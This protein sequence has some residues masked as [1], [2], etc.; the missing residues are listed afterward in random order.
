[1][2]P[3]LVS[4]A[5]FAMRRTMQAT[6]AMQKAAPGDVD[7]E[8]E[9]VQVEVALDE[10][11]P[12]IGLGGHGG[13]SDKQDDHGDV[14]GHMH[15]PGPRRSATFTC[16]RASRTAPRRRS[17]RLSERFSGSPIFHRRQRRTKKTTA[18]ASAAMKQG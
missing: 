11:E 7:G 17:P 18:T 2:S 15:E 12:Q 1:M 16:R 3:G 5:R 8:R 4:S 13:G 9:K 14:H 6:M 10:R